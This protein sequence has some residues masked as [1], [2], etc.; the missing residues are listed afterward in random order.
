M[1]A[2]ASCDYAPRN[3]DV[4]EPITDFV[5]AELAW[6]D[7]AQQKLGRIP[8]FIRAMVKKRTESYVTDLGEELITVEH[9]KRLSARRF[10]GNLPWKRP[11]SGGGET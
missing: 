7:E 2:D 4:I 6:S 11:E 8:G 5:A 9:M 3:K 1:D 10:G